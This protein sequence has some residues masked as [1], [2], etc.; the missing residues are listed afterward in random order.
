MSDN[1]LIIA[2]LTGLPSDYDMIR[3]VI[4]ACKSPITL[5]E[6]RAQLI[7]AEKT[8]ETRMQ[9]LV[10]S[11]SAMY[12]NANASN[13]NAR[14]SSS[15][16]N[17][18]SSSF[19]SYS[20]TQFPPNVGSGFSD[21]LSSHTS[22]PFMGNRFQSNG[23]LGTYLTGRSFNS[24]NYRPRGNGGYKLRFNSSRFG[25]NWQPWSGNTSNRFEHIPEHQI[26]SRKGHT[27][28]TCLYR[29]DNGLSVQE[30]QI[31]GK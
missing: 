28:V 1:D 5:K 14:G 2:A 23:S 7:D 21:G 10:Q 31:C 26:C 18:S 19:G 11:M 29:N 4:L 27:I 15:Q 9:S 20:T 16:F 24:N 13:D 6:F 30:C 17:G 3:T 25:N 22:Y 8:I 12:V